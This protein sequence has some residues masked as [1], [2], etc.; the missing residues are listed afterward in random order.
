MIESALWLASAADGDVAVTRPGWIDWVLPLGISF[1]TFQMLS[2]MIGIIPRHDMQTDRLPGL[3]SPT[4]PSFHNSSRDPSFTSM[5]S[6]TSCSVWNRLRGTTSG[7][8]PSSSR[9][10]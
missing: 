7:S 6:S 8:A 5:S 2:A 3:V 9:A 4:S 10:A 1:Y